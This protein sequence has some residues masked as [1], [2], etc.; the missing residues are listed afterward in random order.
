MTFHR[1]FAVLSLGVSAAV[2]G[3]VFTVHALKGGAAS[4]LRRGSSAPFRPLSSR[5]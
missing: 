5:Q 1:A 3:I 2:V 4:L